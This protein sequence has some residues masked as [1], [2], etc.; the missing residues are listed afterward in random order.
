MRRTNQNAPI[1]DEIPVSVMP[2]QCRKS[3]VHAELKPKY[4]TTAQ[5]RHSFFVPLDAILYPVRYDTIL[6]YLIPTTGA[7]FS[8]IIHSFQPC[9]DKDKTRQAFSPR[10]IKPE[11]ENGS[12]QTKNMLRKFIER[13]LRGTNLE[14][15]KVG[16]FPPTHNRNEKRD[17]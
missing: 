14:I 2:P 13:T 17:V 1:A 15:F 9:R 11:T 4:S 7:S 5:A 12:G 3:E 10:K 8:F 16:V 6:S